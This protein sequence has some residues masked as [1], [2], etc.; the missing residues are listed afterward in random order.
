MTIKIDKLIFCEDC[1]SEIINHKIQS[2]RSGREKSVPAIVAQG[3]P[4]GKDALKI[5]LKLLERVFFRLVR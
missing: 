5:F 2:G 4:L 1:D 3:R